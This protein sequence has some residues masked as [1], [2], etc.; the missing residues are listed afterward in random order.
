MTSY[1]LINEA[2]G[3]LCDDLSCAKS[4]E[5]DVLAGA[6]VKLALAAFI[7][8]HQSEDIEEN[9]ESLHF[10]NAENTNLKAALE[11]AEKDIDEN[12]VC[13]MCTRCVPI[14]VGTAQSKECDCGF[15]GLRQ[16]YKKCPHFE[17]K[18]HAKV[19]KLKMEL[20]E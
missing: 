7:L 9:E 2:I 20:E 6:I 16:I 18:Q 3:S 15:R 11:I 14:T 19:T 13:A 12:C 17:W 5:K 1:K 10:L 8:Q 4:N